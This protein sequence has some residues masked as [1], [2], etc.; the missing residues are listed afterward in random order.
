MSENAQKSSLPE[1]LIDKLDVIALQYPITEMVY[2]PF[3]L[4]SLQIQQ[5]CECNI[6]FKECCNQ[7]RLLKHKE[8][9]QQK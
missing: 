2:N 6:F 5:L 4:P 8:A 9:Q 1:D 7:T 3:M